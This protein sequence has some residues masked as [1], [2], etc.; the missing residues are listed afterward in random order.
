MIRLI[1]AI[2][3][4]G[5]ILFTGLTFAMRTF[6]DAQPAPQE[7]IETLHLT[8][9][10]LPCWAGVTPGKTGQDEAIQRLTA[11]YPDL[12]V[13]NGSAK[14][15]VYTHTYNIQIGM[16]KGVVN[17]VLIGVWDNTLRLGDL[18]ALY[19]KPTCYAS[20]DP[21]RPMYG[22]PHVSVAITPDEFEGYRMKETITGISIRN[23]MGDFVCLP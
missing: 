14:V 1:V 6:E 5:S 23:L 9:C 10:D 18:I 22:F 3:L 11:I 13:V 19:G 4:S 17:Y 7:I 21:E 12:M 8:D 2:S 16:E 20:A 15:Y